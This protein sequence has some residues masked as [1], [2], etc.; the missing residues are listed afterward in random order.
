MTRDKSPRTFQ[1]PATLN[2]SVKLQKPSLGVQQLYQRSLTSSESTESDQL[3]QRGDAVPDRWTPGDPH[4]ATDFERLI[5]EISNKISAGCT[6]DE[7]KLWASLADRLKTVARSS[8]RWKSLLS[9]GQGATP[10]ALIEQLFKFS[11]RHSDETLADLMLQIGADPNQK[12]LGNT[13]A[14]YYAVGRSKSIVALLLSSGAVCTQV[15]L[16][17]AIVAGEFDIADLML[18]SNSSLDLNFNYHDICSNFGVLK[19]ETVTLLALMSW[20]NTGACCCYHGVET[21]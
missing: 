3:V 11:I 12:V 9:N 8:S 20:S 21:P 16:M 15:T 6:S 10:R 17:R 4:I 5:F 14:L 7:E 1:F 2:V 13:S 19:V 18:Q